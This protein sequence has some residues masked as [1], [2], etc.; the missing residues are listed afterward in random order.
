M[1]VRN[2]SEKSGISGFWC[3]C[4]YGVGVGYVCDMGALGLR[5]W[6]WRSRCAEDVKKSGI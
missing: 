5:V 1:L 2:R 6:V 4:V 3:S